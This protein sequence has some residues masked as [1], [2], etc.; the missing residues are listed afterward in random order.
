MLQLDPDDA[1]EDENSRALTNLGG[2][3][4]APAA[5]LTEADQVVLQNYKV[6]CF[7]IFQKFNMGFAPIA[8]C[9]HVFTNICTC[10]SKINAF[11]FTRKDHTPPKVPKM[12][13]SH[14]RFDGEAKRTPRS[15][16]SSE[17]A[18]KVRHKKKRR[19]IMSDSESDEND[20]SDPDFLV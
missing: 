10:A 9:F 17:K 16:R 1:E 3:L 14:R 5:I 13:I 11:L 12:V 6:R 2:N 19:K 20:F 4:N 8:L 7:M 18:R 15:H